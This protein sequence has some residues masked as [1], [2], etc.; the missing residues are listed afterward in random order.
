MLSA[1]SVFLEKTKS[2]CTTQ[3]CFAKST[4]EGKNICTYLPHLAFS[5]ASDSAV[6]QPQTHFYAL[7]VYSC[8]H[9]FL[10]SLP[11]RF[12]H[13]L[14]HIFLDSSRSSL[15]G[16]HSSTAS[17]LLPNFYSQTSTSKR[18][19]PCFYTHSY[20]P[21]LLHTSTGILIHP[22]HF[23]PYICP[24]LY[25]YFYTHLSFYTNIPAHI[26]LLPYFYFLPSASKLLDTYL[27]TARATLLHRSPSPHVYFYYH[28][29]TSTLLHP[30]S[31]THIS[32][33]SSHLSSTHISTPILPLPHLNILTYTHTSS[34]VS[35]YF[36]NHCYIHVYTHFYIDFYTHCYPYFDTSSSTDLHM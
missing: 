21:T 23:F 26:L 33:H 3:R 1:L 29:S 34:H 17:L 19:Y 32:T 15:H 20:S 13:T 6:L 31:S 9:N 25:S 8:L 28:T 4:S 30:H 2:P 7:I 10:H 14:L 11:Y 27:C 18:L 35:I 36:Y 12:L 5:C 24:P 16:T 22:H